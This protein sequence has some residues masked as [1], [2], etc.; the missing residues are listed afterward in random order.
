MLQVKNHTC[1]KLL[2][3]ET[4]IAAYPGVHELMTTVLNF[5]F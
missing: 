2:T 5:A 3:W 4:Y 1:S